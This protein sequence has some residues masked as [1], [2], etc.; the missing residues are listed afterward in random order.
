MRCDPPSRERACSVATVCGRRPDHRS[1]PGRDPA[2]GPLWEM[3]IASGVQ[4]LMLCTCAASA[5]VSSPAASVTAMA[6][7][8]AL[9]C[10]VIKGKPMIQLRQQP[11]DARGE[12]DEAKGADGKAAAKSKKRASSFQS[13]TLSRYPVLLPKTIDAMLAGG[14]LAAAIALLCIAQGVVGLKLF[15][16]PMM[17]SGIIFF[18][19]KRPPPVTGFAVGTLAGTTLCSS[20]FVL[21]KQW[22]VT[23]EYGLA[24]G[25]L[26]VVYKM[27]N[28]MFPPAAVLSVLIAQELNGSEAQELNTPLA[29]ARFACFPWLAGH[30][31]LYGG[32]LGMAEVRSRTRAWIMQSQLRS[33]INNFAPEALRESFDRLDTSGDG[34]LDAEELMLAL[35]MARGEFVSK[36]EAAELIGSADADGDGVIDFRE[37]CDICNGML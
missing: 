17:A 6:P 34:Y 3:Y 32:A 23:A 30:A 14:G 4:A 16:A 7:S 9:A 31:V 13:Q 29:V 11:P 18:A 36:E 35:R 33:S 20:A 22:G 26:L 10:K 24:A 1:A 12:R 25:L 37:F 27:T 2:R 5:F 21:T 15:V 19:A 8:R 28:S